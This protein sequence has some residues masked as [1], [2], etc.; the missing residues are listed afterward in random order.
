MC[1][2]E[3]PNCGA[4]DHSPVHSK[5]ISA[6]IDKN[7]DGKLTIYYSSPKAGHSPEYEFLATVTNPNLAQLLVDIA[8]DL[9]RP[10]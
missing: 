5:D 9:A 4:S 3:C 10:I 6:F 1:D 2:D 8:F 7:E